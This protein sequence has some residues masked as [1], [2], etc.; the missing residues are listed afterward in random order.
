[1][2]LDFETRAARYVMEWGEWIEKLQLLVLLGF[3]VE[4]AKIYVE[5]LI[6]LQNQDGGFPKNW[7]KGNPSSLMET[8]T[9]LELLAKMKFKSEVM[10]KAAKFLADKQLANGS[11]REEIREYGERGVKKQR[12]TL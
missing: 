1:M 12:V 11:W 9:A 10:R 5:K 2:Q 3:K 6:S 7:I 8:A 4:R